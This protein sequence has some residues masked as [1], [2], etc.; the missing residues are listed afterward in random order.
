MKKLLTIFFVLLL[1]ASTQAQTIHTVP[2]YTNYSYLRDSLLSNGKHTL[3]IKSD[4]LI[5]YWGNV[6]FIRQ[7]IG[8]IDITGNFKI[9]GVTLSS[10]TRPDT[11]LIF[12]KSDTS[13]LVHNYRTINGRPL[14]SNIVIDTTLMLYKSDSTRFFSVRLDSNKLIYTNRAD[15]LTSKMYFNN[16]AN[17]YKGVGT[18]LTALSATQLTTGTI[19]DARYGDGHSDKVYTDV[20]FGEEVNFNDWYSANTF[21]NPNNIFYGDGANILGLQPNNMTF[22]IQAFG[23]SHGSKSIDLNLSGS[24]ITV[25]GNTTINA[26]GAAGEKN[27]L[28]A[29]YITSNGTN[30]TVTFGTNIYSTGTLTTGTTSGKVFVLIFL[31]PDGTKYYEIS[32]TGAL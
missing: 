9:N 29:I 4:S 18:S 12:Y 22:P 21:N 7:I 15:T 23:T 28:Y 32:R 2:V 19:P 27:K 30:Y 11:T 24:T 6:K 31:S 26:T 20:L 10:S 25:D 13:G 5:E 1:C 17:V 16:T 14:S 3:R 8:D